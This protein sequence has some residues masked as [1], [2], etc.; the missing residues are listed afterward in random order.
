MNKE[1]KRKKPKTDWGKLKS[2]RDDQIDLTDSPELTDEF[3]D[4]AE[5]GVLAKKVPLSIRLDEDVV[6]WFKEQGAGYQTRINDVLRLYVN[7]QT[8]EEPSSYAGVSA[9]SIGSALVMPM[10]PNVMSPLLSMGIP[11]VNNPETVQ[12]TM[13]LTTVNSI[14][15]L[16]AQ[17]GKVCEAESLYKR[18]LRIQTKALG[19]TDA[20]IHAAIIEMNKMAN[21]LAEA[22]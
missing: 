10:M 18:V 14:A 16:Y 3:W 17:Q 8:K 12:M 1:E 5:V 13:V 2:L 4:N 15:C 11:A 9:G 22:L 6:A 19:A 7:H 21:E 20:G